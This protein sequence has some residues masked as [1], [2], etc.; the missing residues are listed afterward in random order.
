[1]P[2]PYAPKGARRQRAIDAYPCQLILQSECEQLPAA[3]A[4][5]LN[6][7]RLALNGLSEVHYFLHGDIVSGPKAVVIP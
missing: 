5:L 4:G 3:A 1:M 7:F 2:P 6:G